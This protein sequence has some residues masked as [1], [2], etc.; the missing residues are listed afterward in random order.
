MYRI[1][2]NSQGTIGRKLLLLATI[3]VTLALL[4]ACSVFA[5]FGIISL[6]NAK[7]QQ[8]HSQAKL[9]ALNSAA[10]VEFA[11]TVQADRLLAAL[12]SDP[13]VTSA[14][15]YSF[16]GALIGSYP[17]R[18]SAESSFAE[19]AA[20]PVGHH[21]LTQPIVSDGES[22]GHLKL[23]VDFA[24][25]GAA[26]REYATLTV[27]VGIWSWIVAVCVAYFSQRSIVRPI[28]HL[29]E[30]ARNVTNDGNYAVRVEGTV[31]GELKDLYRA[32]NGMLTQIQASK[33]ELQQVNDGLEQRVVERTNDLARARDAAEAAS[34]AKSD[35]LANM[36]HEIR[37]PLNAIMGYADLLRRGWVESQAE[38]EEMLTTVH[39]SGRH[40]MTVLNDILDLSKIESGRM[41]LEL[42][43][44]SPHQILSEVVSLMRVSFREKNLDLEY[45]WQGPI[46]KLIETD[47]ARLHQ[48]L[49][50][51]MGNARKFTLS[52]VVQIVAR[53]DRRAPDSRLI[54]DVIDTGVGIPLEKQAQ[55]FEPF[56]QADTSV[57]RRFGGTGLG[58]SISRRL[59]RMMGGDLTL[60]SQ[61]GKG[62]CFTLVIPTGVLTDESFGVGGPV[63]DVIP[64][65]RP[66]D[67]Q[68]ALANQLQGLRVLVVDDG[69]A[70]RKLLSLILTR[71][72]A[73]IF[74][75]EN[76][77]EACN[78]V[79]SGQAI[80]AIL[81]DMQMPV[82]DGYVAAKKLRDAGI[83]TPIVALT[84]HAMVGDREKC[85]DAGCSDFLTKPV[86]T[87]DLLARMHSIR[88]SS[89]VRAI[90]T[91]SLCQTQPIHSKLPTDDLEFAEIVVDFVTAL[92][93][94]VGRLDEAVRHR[95]PIGTMTAAHWIKGSGGTAGFSCF[96]N[97]AME[98]CEAVRSNNWGDVERQLITI[99]DYTNRVQSPELVVAV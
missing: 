65:R 71:A 62:S 47:S 33:L 35:F 37:T 63:G 84:A 82:M 41:E 93:R 13:S 30:V 89:R 74:Q 91:A 20:V 2:S 34:R 32:F 81:L 66:R 69:A 42:R 12:Q 25:L 90:S 97:P 55:V 5:A 16:E 40:L 21:L 60:T 15:L 38:R 29:A 26:V 28:D 7:W 88:N 22:V 85:V 83:A 14:A 75:A 92:K 43:P 8:L 49:V 3:S 96:T 99:S 46:P 50:N 53:L 19:G 79:L 48:I 78:L 70:N 51:L 57:T 64:S 17:S 24:S 95:D 36:S 94:E 76:G 61:P 72:G 54:V 18:V 86:N 39:S 4:L 80:D 45:H 44:E 10:A 77:L 11:D 27:F 87:D 1:F 68:G 9:L 52:G 98:I 31:E 67:P 58:L 6:K 56:V 23:L 73:E 59:A